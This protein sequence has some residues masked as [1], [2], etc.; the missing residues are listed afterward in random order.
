L[1]YPSRHWA[2]LLT[3][4][5]AARTRAELIIAENG[6]S[7]QQLITL[8]RQAKEAP[9]SQAD[10]LW[11]VFHQVISVVGWQSSSSHA[12]EMR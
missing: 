8:N 10:R 12:F 4:L 6:L 11:L 7:S 3:A 9:L 5:D 1:I 2:I